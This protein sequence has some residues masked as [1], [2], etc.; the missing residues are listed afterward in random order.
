MNLTDLLNKG[1]FPKELPPCFTTTEFASKFAQVN[2]DLLANEAN[3]L[4]VVLQKIQNNR[5]LSQPTKDEEKARAKQTFK[6]RLKFS[7]CVQ[8]TI[9]KVGLT[10]NTIK[11]PNPLHQGKLSECIVSNYNSIERLFGE[12]NLSTTKPIIE[13]AHGEGKRAVTHENYGYF[14]EQSIIKS[15]SYP[16]YLKT[17]IAKFYS[18][19]YTHT[20][21]WVTFG[22]K[23]RYKRNRDLHKSDINKVTS[24]Y[25][26]SIDDALTWCQN[27]QTMGIPIGPDSSLIVAEIIACHIDKLLE[28][29]L[30]RKKID[31]IGF[32]YYDDYSM[33]FHSELDAQTAL[34]E[35]RNVLA[36]FELKINDEK[37]VIGIS[38]N[39]LEK[40]WALALKSFFF[41]PA[42]SD[43]RE[44]IWSFFSIAFKYA[45]EYPKES[46]LKLALNKFTF[47][48]IEKE[49]W[50]FFESLLFRLGLTEPS[51]LSKLSKILISYSTLVNKKKLK[52]FC[53]ELINRHAAKSNDYELTWAVWLLKEFELFP[54]KEIYTAIFKSKSVCASLIALEL[55]S[56]NTSIKTFDYS[57][58]EKLFTIENLNKQFWLLIYECIYK[59]WLR[60]VIPSTIVTN[61]FYFNTLKKNNVFFY[62]ESKKIEPLSIEK[63]YFDKI[64]RKISQVD[65]YIKD[66]PFQNRMIKSQIKTLSSLLL[67]GKNKNLVNREDIQKILESSD[68]LIK[69]IIHELDELRIKQIEFDDKR[70]YFALGKRMEE[71]N[72][73]TAKEMNL[74]TKE[75]NELLFDPEYE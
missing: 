57:D 37:T 23:D 75:D 53:Y 18:S 21:P 40:D 62:D 11:I 51:S 50:D 70:I 16:V 47:V 65:K 63:S 6:N 61:H 3:A 25:G 56:Q 74:Q 10:R 22:G 43:Q 20:V 67:I 48:R 58:L 2:I 19:I 34:S 39:E 52:I 26:D 71:L 41:R 27:Q 4:S 5:V 8:F 9:P 14:K 73:L 42:E 49:N 12:S 38:A 31:W 29:H 55:L 13:T 32:R 44:D 68:R 35:L 45:K 72:I 33:F 24:I 69:K 60:H 64:E 15:F 46:V 36:D 59:Q 7:D 28:G 1:Y 54:T 66:N 30:K 17:D